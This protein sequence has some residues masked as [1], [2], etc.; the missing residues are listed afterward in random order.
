MLTD[1]KEP[2]STMTRT[3]TVFFTAGAILALLGCPM[4]GDS[5]PTSTVLTVDGGGTLGSVAS[6]D[7]T[8]YS[9]T[10]SGT[11]DYV[12]SVY[13]FTGDPNLFVCSEIPC[14]SSVAVQLG[15]SANIEEDEF[16]RLDAP[17]SVVV[18]VGVEG[19]NGQAT[20]TVEVTTG[21]DV[22]IMTY[23]N[24]ASSTGP[25]DYT[26]GSDTFIVVYDERQV[27]DLGSGIGTTG[28]DDGGFAGGGFS[29]TTSLLES[30]KSYH[31]KVTGNTIGRYTVE[32]N[33]T[34]YV[35]GPSAGDPAV[36]VN[37]TNDTAAQ[38]TA[39]VIGT[40]SDNIIEVGDT[41]DWFA[42]DVP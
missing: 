6:G 36:D 22:W 35:A 17:S 10:A 39:L 7:A 16:V 34:G 21:V 33:T 3:F 2:S 41:G 11:D 37:E 20:Y 24:A 4:T 9:Y 27:L 26:T 42:F 13:D 28:S 18:Y 5:G 40:P 12:I 19:F 38:A 8:Q 15:T 32:V 25:P 23:D 31:V 30:G 1:S 14:D 29:G